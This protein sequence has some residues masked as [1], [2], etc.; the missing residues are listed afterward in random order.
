MKFYLVL[1]KLQGLFENASAE[2][3]RNLENSNVFRSLTKVLIIGFTKAGKKR[4]LAFI[5]F[6]IEPILDSIRKGVT[7]IFFLQKFCCYPRNRQS[8]A[9]RSDL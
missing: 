7:I 2:G 3:K 1:K 9:D 6:L 8:T 5:Q 4:R